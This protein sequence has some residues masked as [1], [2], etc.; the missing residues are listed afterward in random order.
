MKGLALDSFEGSQLIKKIELN[1]QHLASSDPMKENLE[2]TKNKEQIA[3]Y[4]ESKQNRNV[5]RLKEAGL[6]PQE[7]KKA[8]D[9]HNSSNQH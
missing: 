8:D 7:Q 4:P 2:R 9:L 5:Y 3:I 6:S 1:Q